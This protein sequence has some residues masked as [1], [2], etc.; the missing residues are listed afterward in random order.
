MGR[1][2]W[3]WKSYEVWRIFELKLARLLTFENYERCRNTKTFSFLR[4][5]Y[6][7]HVLKTCTELGA[8]TVNKIQIE[9]R[10]LCPWEISSLFDFFFFL[11]ISVEFKFCYSQSKVLQNYTLLQYSNYLCDFKCLF[12]GMHVY[13]CGCLYAQWNNNL[14]HRG[15]PSTITDFSCYT[16]LCFAKN[17]EFQGPYC[18]TEPVLG[19]TCTVPCKRNQ[20]LG[21]THQSHG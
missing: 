13:V 16:L 12:M 14:I 17:W 19:G 3:K 6:R 10:Y 18:F 7:K 1:P 15:V 20:G 21:V 4:A 2:W 8:H 5:F 11:L 9:W